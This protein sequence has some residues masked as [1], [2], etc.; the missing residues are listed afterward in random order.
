[1][2]LGSGRQGRHVLERGQLVGGRLIG[3][4]YITLR[5]SDEHG[6]TNTYHRYQYS[7]EVH[8]AQPYVAGVRQILRPDQFERLGMDLA[9]RDD[10]GSHLP[11]R[12][13]RS[14]AQRA[15]G[16]DPR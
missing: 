7:V 2:V 15:A 9:V 12:A 3:I 5:S 10:H 11:H 14:R 1:M 13:R 6:S 8:A 4:E 16:P